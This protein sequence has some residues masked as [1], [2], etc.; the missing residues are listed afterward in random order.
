MPINTTFGSIYELLEDYI[1]W[2][3]LLGTN[4]WVE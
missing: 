2:T 3:T 4:V 1:E